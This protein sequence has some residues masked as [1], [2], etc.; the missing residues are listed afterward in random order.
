MDKELHSDEVMSPLSLQHCQTKTNPGLQ[1][2]LSLSA[3]QHTAIDLYRR[4]LNVLPLPRPQEVN[5][6][7]GEE[8]QDK[9]A[10]VKKLFFT[11]RLHICTP[12]CYRRNPNGRLPS[13][14]RI[15]TLF[16][17]ANIGVMTGRTSGNLFSLDCDSMRTYQ[18]VKDVLDTLDLS[19][20]QY[21]SYRGGIFLMR[22]LEGEAKN[23]KGYLDDLDIIGNLNYV[24]LPPSIHPS[25]MLYR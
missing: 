8:I 15:E 5:A 6:Y 12:E 3:I 23:G 21:E 1:P 14:Y 9:P 17:G 10:Y 18:L 7:Y 4:R 11:S 24:V 20:W 19:Y 13:E 25:G 16:K 22:L 2:R